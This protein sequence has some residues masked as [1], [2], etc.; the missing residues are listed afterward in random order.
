MTSG[1]SGSESGGSCPACIRHL[2]GLQGH[3][4]RL[5]AG[6][7]LGLCAATRN[8]HQGPRLWLRTWAESHGHRHPV[9]VPLCPRRPHRAWKTSAPPPRKT[10]LGFGK[11]PSFKVSVWPNFLSLWV[12][13]CML[14][15]D[16]QGT[17]PWV[18]PDVFSCW[19]ENISPLRPAWERGVEGWV[20]VGTYFEKWFCFTHQ[21]NIE[22]IEFRGP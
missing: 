19:R 14:L 4:C 10:A 16:G 3:R 2:P 13:E 8:S 20:V 15:C 9:C 22:V 11:V 21:W 5:N 12:S 17:L 18:Q 1:A 7:L 6:G